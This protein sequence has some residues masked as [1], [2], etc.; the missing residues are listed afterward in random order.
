MTELGACWY[1]DPQRQP[2]LGWCPGSCTG[3]VTYSE[4]A[5]NGDKR[6]YC[7]THAYWRRKTI[8]LPLVRRMRPSEQP[9]PSRSHS[10]TW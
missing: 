6:V 10:D 3:A 2:A 7:D 4:R 5:S 9:R 8:R 1:S